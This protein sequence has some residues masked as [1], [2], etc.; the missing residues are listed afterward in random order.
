MEIR[1]LSFSYKKAGIVFLVVAVLLTILYFSFNFRF[2]VPVFAV[3]SSFL[4]IK[5]F[6]VFKTNFADELIMLLF[7]SGFFFVI[8]SE[9]KVE[10][11]V[12]KEFRV[13]AFIQ[14]VKYY[15]AFLLLSI[16]F[17]YGNGF[18]SLLVLNMFT[19]FIFYLL[20]FYRLKYRY[21]KNRKK[22]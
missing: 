20:I 8:F 6:T 11:A 3:F 10:N 13:K 19:L 12:Y 15:G 22:L 14:S 9:E 17:I 18:I 21:I 7:L 2:S 1:L 5:Y 4:E 16:L